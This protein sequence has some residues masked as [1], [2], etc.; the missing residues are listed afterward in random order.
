MGLTRRLLK[1][2][3]R[4][5]LKNLQQRHLHVDVVKGSIRIDEA[6]INLAPLQQPLEG[7]ALPA[8]LELTQVSSLS[9]ELPLRRTRATPL[10]SLAHLHRLA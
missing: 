4:K 3:L 5:Y 7:G 8:G 2:L 9:L 10:A 6:D 1:G